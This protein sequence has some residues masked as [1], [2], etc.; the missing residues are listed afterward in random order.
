MF[1]N[2]LPKYEYLP[3]DAL[4]Q[5]H[6]TALMVLEKFGVEFN[7]PEAVELLERAG[8]EVADR[9]NNLIKFPR[10]LVLDSIAKAPSE[11][12]VRARNPQH[13]IIIGGNHMVMAPVYGPPFVHDLDRGRR[14]A[15]IEDFRN[16]VK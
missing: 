7:H 9:E 10:Q 11:F 8:A 13:G 15:K 6:E 4:D 1:T 14:D 2:S 12:P 16:F 5:I 3:S